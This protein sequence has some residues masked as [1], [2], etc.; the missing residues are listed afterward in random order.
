[1]MCSFILGLYPSVKE[2]N[3][4][5][6]VSLT[7]P[8]RPWA[9]APPCQGWH[10]AGICRSC[11]HTNSGSGSTQLPTALDLDSTPFPAVCIATSVIRKALLY[12]KAMDLSSIP[13]SWYWR[14][15]LQLMSILQERKQILPHC[16]PFQRCLSPV[17]AHLCRLSFGVICIVD[18]SGLNF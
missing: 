1:M 2:M 6:R 15:I 9:R 8:Q 5:K 18:R 7:S 17:W 10:T 11:I 12:L 16:W 4:Q 3:E 14:Q 13:F